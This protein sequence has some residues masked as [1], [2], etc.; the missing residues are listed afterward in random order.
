MSRI[1]QCFTT[2]PWYDVETGGM[3]YVVVV[4]GMMQRVKYI[5]DNNDSLIILDI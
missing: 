1:A 3:W 5:G 4:C 2:G